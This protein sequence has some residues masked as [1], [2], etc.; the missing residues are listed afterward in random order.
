MIVKLEKG[1]KGSPKI[2]SIQVFEEDAFFRTANPEDFKGIKAWFTYVYKTDL[3]TG[4]LQLLTRNVLKT[5]FKI[6]KDTEIYNLIFEQNYG[7]K[8]W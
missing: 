8:K 1:Y 4:K 6:Y 5:Y 2:N 3:A 7:R